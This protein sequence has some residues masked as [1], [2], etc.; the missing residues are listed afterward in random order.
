MS[1][2]IAAVDDKK[3]PSSIALEQSSLYNSKVYSIIT[4]WVLISLGTLYISFLLFRYCSWRFRRRRVKK[5]RMERQKVEKFW[6]KRTARLNALTATSSAIQSPIQ[7]AFDEEQYTQ[8]WSPSLDSSAT[9]V[10]IVSSSDYYMNE[11]R[12]LNFAESVEEAEILMEQDEAP[13]PYYL[14]HH[15]TMYE[16]SRKQG[17]NS[18]NHIQAIHCAATKRRKSTKERLTS[19]IINRVNGNHERKKKRQLLWQWSVA[20]GYCKYYHGYRLNSIVQRLSEKRQKS[21][22]SNSSSISDTKVHED[23]SSYCSDHNDHN[24]FIRA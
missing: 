22:N 16:S 9:L 12:Y 7:A 21:I 10:G 14:K 20:M 18:L 4:P 24:N 5:I 3:I 1:N 19:M 17:Q 8:H 6:R 23:N 11:Q 2:T 13:L 15:N